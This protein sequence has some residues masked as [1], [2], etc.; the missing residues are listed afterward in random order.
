MRQGVGLLGRF[1]FAPGWHPTDGLIVF[2]VGLQLMALMSDLWS[3]V[4]A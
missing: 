4:W 1:F 3:S 2:P